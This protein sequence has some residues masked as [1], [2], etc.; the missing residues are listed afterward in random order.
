[1]QN[2]KNSRRW[3]NIYDFLNTQHQNHNPKKKKS[4]K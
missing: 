2:N 3:E 4:G 1:M